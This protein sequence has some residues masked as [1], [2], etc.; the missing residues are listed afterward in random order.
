MKEGEEE[1]DRVLTSLSM[2]QRWRD[3]FYLHPASLSLLA[4][5]FPMSPRP[6][7]PT[8]KSSILVVEVEEKCGCGDE[9]KME[10]WKKVEEGRKAQT[11][12]IALV[13]SRDLS[14]TTKPLAKM[15]ANDFYIEAS[16]QL[17]L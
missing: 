8:T 16:I 5:I 17:K 9:E 6:I 2:A 14:T 3:N 15:R 1:G 4:Y 11:I 13:G 7:K 10:L 12:W